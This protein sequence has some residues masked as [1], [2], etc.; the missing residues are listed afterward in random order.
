M[1]TKTKTKTNLRSLDVIA[2]EI[3]QHMRDN[4]FAVGDLLIEAHAACA[5]GD[6]MQWLADNFA[7][8]PDTASRLMAVAMLANKFR[9][10][11]NLKLSR[12]TLYRLADEDKDLQPAM[13]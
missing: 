6:W 10:L 3:H 1:N 8:S 11:R 7:L 4:V 12:T 13:I 5:H 2:G 9:K